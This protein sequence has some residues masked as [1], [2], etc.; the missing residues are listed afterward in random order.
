MVTPLT[1]LQA[2]EEEAGVKI[3]DVLERIKAFELTPGEYTAYPPGIVSDLQKLAEFPEFRLLKMANA[4]WE[5]WPVTVYR[6]CKVQACALF[7]VP[8]EIFV[9][10]RGDTGN[11][12]KTWLQSVMSVVAGEYYEPIDEGMITQRPPHPKDCNSALFSLIGKRALGLPEVEKTIKVQGSWLK[13]LADPATVWGTR[14]PYGTAQINFKLCAVFCLSTNAKLDFTHSDGGIRRRGVGVDYPFHFCR[15]PVQLHERL[16]AVEDIKDEKFL[17]E[18]IPGWYYFLECVHKVFYTEGHYPTPGPLPY[19]VKQA[20]DE[21]H[22]E[23]AHV[24]LNEFAERKLEDSSGEQAL[25]KSGLLTLCGLDDNLKHMTR[26]ELKT[27]VEG[28]FAFATVRGLRDRVKLSG[29]FK[30]E[31]LIAM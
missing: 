23:E 2:R 5:N 28:V 31:K 29:S 20:T 6:A 3:I 30:K 24:A 21:L 17:M 26:A 27:A 9:H 16:A 10:D 1:F 18:H 12:G 22:S 11:N 15:N 14:P 25:S 13:K 4:L 19:L 8:V 7:A